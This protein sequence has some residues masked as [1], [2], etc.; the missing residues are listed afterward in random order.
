MRANKNWKKIETKPR[1]NLTWQVGSSKLDYQSEMSTTLRSASGRIAGAVDQNNRAAG[2][3][4]AR[5]A[6]VFLVLLALCF[7]NWALA[8]DAVTNATPSSDTETN[9]QQMLRAYLQLQ[10]QLHLT[11]LA[12]EQNRNEARETAAQNSELLAGRIHALEQALDLQRTRE[13]ETMQSSNRVL[14]AIAGSFAAIGFLAMLLSSFFQWRIFNRLALLPSGLASQVPPG[15]PRQV[16]PGERPVI[17]VDPAEQSSLRLLGAV[18]QLEKRL[19]QLEHTTHAPAGEESSEQSGGNGSARSGENSGVGSRSVQD[20]RVARLLAQGQA[21]LNQDD[22][23][24]ALGCFEEVLS[25]DPHNAEAWVRKGT[26]LERLQQLDQAAE[27]Y[28]RAIQ[29]DSMLTV[30]YLHKG[31]LFNRMERFN[32]A[33]ECYEKALRTQEKQHA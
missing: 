24:A 14:L 32:E 9:S 8:D 29:A 10:E 5:V 23:R 1:P 26:A 7:S 31:G 28:D 19:S 13:L 30:A 4:C 16:G 25:L 12:I 33:L 11:Q 6:V 20:E 17:T 15:I 2:T 18:E 21:M 27:C 3:C 22:V